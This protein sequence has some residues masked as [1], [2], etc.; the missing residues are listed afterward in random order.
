[1]LVAIHYLENVY[2]PLRQGHT[3]FRDSVWPHKQ[4]WRS[5]RAVQRRR[6]HGGENFRRRAGLL[7]AGGRKIFQPTRVGGNPELAGTS[8]R[9]APRPVY[10][11]RRWAESYS[12]RGATGKIGIPELQG[13]RRDLL[14]H[15][16]AK[17]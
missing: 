5:L 13:G 1:L 16:K 3:H 11:L 2:G 6:T 7:R 8:G 9:G 4:A 14:L 10:M 12:T 15:K 17:K